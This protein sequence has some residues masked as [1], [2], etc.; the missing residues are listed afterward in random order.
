MTQQVVAALFYPGCEPW[1]G[2]AEKQLAAR[3]LEKQLA[4]RLLEKQLAARPESA[5]RLL[6]K[7]AGE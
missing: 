7:A 6:R 3:L 1:R 4:G 5:G 2:G